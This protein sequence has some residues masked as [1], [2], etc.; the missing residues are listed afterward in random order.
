MKTR[1]RTCFL[2]LAATAIVWVS[3]EAHAWAKSPT[4][5]CKVYEIRASNEQGGIDTE[6]KG[7]KDL[8]KGAFTK[9]KRFQKL[10]K[11]SKILASL[12]TAN[13]SL[14]PGKL[15]LLLN[16]LIVHPGKKPRIRLAITIDNAKGKRLLNTNSEI[17]AGAYLVWVDE[18]LR[19]PKG[20]YILALTCQP[21][22]KPAKK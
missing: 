21:A 7:I 15:S 13:I 5:E 3:W 12:H 18:R 14:I 19:I 9:W 4:A 1:L 20:T 8:R 11:H 17:D 10:A 6:L 16:D 2:T 22:R